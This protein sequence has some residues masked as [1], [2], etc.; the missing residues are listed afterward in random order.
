MFYLS[1]IRSP[2]N[3][4]Y[5]WNMNDKDKKEGVTR[6]GKRISDGTIGIDFAPGGIESENPQ[7]M[8]AHVTNFT[9]WR[10][11]GIVQNLG[12]GS[13]DFAGI[14]EPTD[15]EGFFRYTPMDNRGLAEFGCTFASEL[16]DFDKIH[17][18]P[19]SIVFFPVAVPYLFYRKLVNSGVR[20]K[21]E[22][23]LGTYQKLALSMSPGAWT[24]YRAKRGNR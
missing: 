8:D 1:G 13:D 9:I 15:R 2:E 21:I 23:D 22:N 14:Y 12:F 4:G 11:K 6:Y 20:K 5:R 16:R 19:F 3:P 7:I 24:A 18:D 17:P 10:E